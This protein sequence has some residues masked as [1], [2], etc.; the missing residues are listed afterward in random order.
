MG[1]DEDTA[2][3]VGLV[4]SEIDSFNEGVALRLLFT[5]PVATLLT[6]LAPITGDPLVLPPKLPPLHEAAP[7]LD[8]KGTFSFPLST[9][10][11][12][13]PTL[14][15][16]FKCIDDTVVIVSGLRVSSES[17]GVPTPTPIP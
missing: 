16:P 6:I 15:L 14:A 2:E 8:D 5:R 1:N 4:E 13:D 3:D 10:L 7:T 12:N 11:I 17:R 9:E